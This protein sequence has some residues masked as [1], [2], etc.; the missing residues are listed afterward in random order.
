[1][2]NIDKW[3]AKRF[4]RDKKGRIV[5]TY[6][7]KIIGNFYEPIIKEHSKG[8]LLDVGCGDVPYYLF[9][10]DIVEEVICIDWENIYL[11]DSHL[12]YVADLNEPMP[13]LES[14]QF[15]TVICTD[16]LEHIHSPNTLFSE[17][18]RVLKPGG[19]LVLCVPFMY[20]IHENPHDHHRYTEFRLDKYCK[21]NGL[22]NVFLEPYGGYPEV[23]FDI[24]AKGY[25]YLNL[26]FRSV[27]EKVWLQMG[28]F[29][30]KRGFV[31][32]M[33]M[34]SRNTFPLGY[35]LVAKK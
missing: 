18:A 2:K 30:S 5:G 3:E 31:R 13:F 11:S 21:D 12:D 23:L 33:S 24:V 16:V 14:D 26:P 8:K 22:K 25:R 1:M 15:D 4:T 32:R 28:L 29:L 27:F 17:M 6:N 9:Y 7:H 20:W 34:N 35:A 19:K 10:K